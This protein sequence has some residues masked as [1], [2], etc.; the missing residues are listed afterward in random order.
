MA[1]SD[2]HDGAL[3][4]LGLASWPFHVVPVQDTTLVW[5]DRKDLH[6]QIHRLVRRLT[7]HQA[8]T[9]HLLWADF[10]A[11]KTHTLLY[12]RQLAHSEPGSVIFPVYTVLPRAPRSFVDIYRAIIQGVGFDRLL[13]VYEAA[14]RSGERS[15]LTHG[16]LSGLTP[17]VATAFEALRIG[18]DTLRQTSIRW[19]SADPSLTRKE[20]QDASLPSKI[21][22]T[23]EALA[24]LASVTRLLISQRSRVLIMVDEFQ[25]SGML[26]RAYLDEI[27][28][29][30]HSYFNDCPL[31]LSLILSFSFGSVDNIRH[32]LNEELRSRADP[33]IFAIPA[34]DKSSA[35][36][37]LLNLITE[38]KAPDKRINI[39]E[40]VY[41]V[42]AEHVAQLG[43][44]SPRRLIQAA[45]SVF[46]EALL[47]LEDEL[48][49]TVNVDYAR[50]ILNNL[51]PVD[52]PD[53]E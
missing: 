12:L 20:L 30:L 1:E 32:H 52:P 23:D 2:V 36:E 44:I 43:P 26:R 39:S 21:R 40:G 53:M 22:S 48:I 5:A 18:N 31:G 6:N 3:E 10:G 46:S 7:R 14:R 11:G 49:A 8:S 25:R 9:L 28:A 17:G 42:I 34:L 38:S 19:L 37:F 45:D 29:G 24:V 51:Q 35:C 27:N 47:D 15:P 13:S 16:S 50:N 33:F 4:L 41:S